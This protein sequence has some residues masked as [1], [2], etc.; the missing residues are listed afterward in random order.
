MSMIGGRKTRHDML[1]EQSEPQD[2]NTMKSG[3]IKTTFGSEF[4]KEAFI[5]RGSVLD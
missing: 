1:F 4:L 3:G 5:K 2:R